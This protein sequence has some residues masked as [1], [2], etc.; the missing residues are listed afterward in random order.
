MVNY[1]NGK[2]YK[3]IA[4]D[5]IY[6]GSTVKQ[7][8]NRMS[9]H[10]T[11]YRRY[12][13]GKRPGMTSFVLFDKHGLENAKIVLLELYPCNS[14]EQLLMKEQEYIDKLDCI[15]K[16][17]AYASAEQ[18]QE[19]VNEAKRRY[20]TRNP[21]KNRDYYHANK[22]Q[23]IQKSKDYYNQNKDKVLQRVKEYNV[24]N[25]E[26]ICENN[27]QY[28]VANKDKIKAHKSQVCQCIC[29]K[30]Y[31]HNHKSRHEKTKFHVKFLE[32]K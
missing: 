24:Q 9:S 30:S 13:Q 19:R 1:Q 11:A 25:K 16:I 10:R 28:R 14:K 3:I 7:L 22:E 26:Q 32:N 12:K 20:S 21:D 2:V 23:C 27:K 17:K 8:S 29:G 15:N 5:L 31:T 18:R 6:V 4:G